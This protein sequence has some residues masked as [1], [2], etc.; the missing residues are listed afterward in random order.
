MKLNPRPAGGGG[1]ESALLP[2]F[3][4][5]SKTVADID[6]KFGYLILHQFDIDCANFIETPSNVF[7]KLRF[8]DVTTSHFWSKSAKCLEI[9]Q[10]SIFKAIYSKKPASM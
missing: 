10:K 4:D 9:H 7:E 5:N 8:C 6:T 1:V 3:R 2:N